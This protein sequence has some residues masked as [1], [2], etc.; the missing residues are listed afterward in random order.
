MS[1]YNLKDRQEKSIHPLAKSVRTL[2]RMGE[3]WGI[4]KALLGLATSVGDNISRIRSGLLSILATWLLTFG[5]DLSLAADFILGDDEKRGRLLSKAGSKKSKKW[6]MLPLLDKWVSHDVAWSELLALAKQEELVVSLEDEMTGM[7]ALCPMSFLTNTQDILVARTEQ[8][9]EVLRR[10]GYKSLIHLGES[11][12]IFGDQSHWDKV[13]I[14]DN[15]G[16]VARPKVEKTKKYVKGLFAPM[17]SI[18]EVN[19]KPNDVLVVPDLTTIEEEA[20]DGQVLIAHSLFVRLL[21][22]EAARKSFVKK[23]GGKTEKHM[24]R[25]FIGRLHVPG[26]G[27]VK[28][29]FVV[30][31]NEWLNFGGVQYAVAASEVK[32]QVKIE[33]KRSILCSASNLKKLKGASTDLQNFLMSLDI[34]SEGFEV[35][36]DEITSHHQARHQDSVDKWLIELEA[37]ALSEEESTEEVMAEVLV[38]K[39]M[40]EAGYDVRSFPRVYVALMNLAGDSEFDPERFRI[41]GETSEGVWRE[42]SYLQVHPGRTVLELEVTMGK[43]RISE[44]DRGFLESYKDLKVGQIMTCT[45]QFEKGKDGVFVTRRPMTLTGGVPMETVE[46]EYLNRFSAVGLLAPV[47]EITQVMGSLDGADYDDSFE[48]NYGLYNDEARKFWTKKHAQFF[49]GVTDADKLWDAMMETVGDRELCGASVQDWMTYANEPNPDLRV[50]WCGMLAEECPLGFLAAN[51]SN[52]GNIPYWREI[53][54]F[55]NGEGSGIMLDPKVAYQSVSTLDSISSWTGTAANAQMFAT[56]VLQ[57]LV[58]PGNEFAQKVAKI[59][60]SAMLSDVIDAVQQGNSVQEAGRVMLILLVGMLV[61]ADILIKMQEKGEEISMPQV[62]FARSTWHM[63]N[64]LKTRTE[65]KMDG[66]WKLVGHRWLPEM[67]ELGPHIKWKKSEWRA[68]TTIESHISWYVDHV[69]SDIMTG[70]YSGET[71]ELAAAARTS[72]GGSI[73]ANVRSIMKFVADAQKISG[74]RS[75]ILREFGVADDENLKE[76]ANRPYQNAHAAIPADMCSDFGRASVSTLAKVDPSKVELGLT[77][78]SKFYITGAGSNAAITGEV[79]VELANWLPS[80]KKDESKSLYLHFFAA[81]RDEHGKIS[82]YLDAEAAWDSIPAGSVVT[83]KDLESHGF[84]LAYGRDPDV[85]TDTKVVNQNRKFLLA[86]L[87]DARVL[88]IEV[89]PRDH[90]VIGSWVLAEVALR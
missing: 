49:N 30:V 80:V 50:A 66:E 7:H 36:V 53:M 79:G 21:K 85:S 16:E 71:A 87:Q 58:F 68:Y 5:Q 65:K 27:L 24:L 84:T 35:L 82:E 28:G 45:S 6:H 8:A 19:V 17:A 20:I 64:L 51:I 47:S 34:A 78:N 60:T 56:F 81:A 4:D 11:R 77:E 32:H 73:P 33:H 72:L 76:W 83:V 29:G 63:K 42:S 89:Q 31:P 86:K 41:S 52:K 62:A 57:D 39:A 15:S 13:V 55:A 18:V 23:A 46:C 3:E 26:L 88:G 54:T 1:K 75:R 67:E 25:T 69:K 40:V 10:N 59:M 38:A 14:L 12:Q 48:L 22:S 9:A 61:F 74:Q 90:K 43:L 2:L 44:E 37:H 70:L